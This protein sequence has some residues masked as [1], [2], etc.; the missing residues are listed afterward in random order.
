MVVHFEFIDLNDLKQDYWRE[1]RVASI[2]VLLFFRIALI[3]GCRIQMPTGK[4]QSKRNS[5]R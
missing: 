1:L 5:P 4:N 2:D 3:L